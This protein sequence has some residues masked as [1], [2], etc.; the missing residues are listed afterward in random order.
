MAAPSPEL[1]AD[2]ARTAV[3]VAFF[4]VRL[5]FFSSRIRSHSFANAGVMMRGTIEPFSPSFRGFFVERMRGGGNNGASDGS[6]S[7]IEVNSA[8]RAMRGAR[9][10][11]TASCIMANTT[12]IRER[13]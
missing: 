7:I 3:A 10:L 13:T 9:V 1:S 11:V 12:E 5:F 4:F 2:G 6:I 8:G